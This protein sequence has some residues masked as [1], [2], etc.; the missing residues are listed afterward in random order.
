ML[1]GE[2]RFGSE[3]TDGATSRSGARSNA[4]GDAWFGS[5][6]ETQ[7]DCP[8]MHEPT[9]SRLAGKN[10]TT[11]ERSVLKLDVPLKGTHATPPLAWQRRY[12]HTDGWIEPWTR[13]RHLQRGLRFVASGHGPC[14]VGS[15]EAHAKSA[16]SCRSP[17]RGGSEL[18]V[19]RK[20]AVPCNSP[21]LSGF[22]PCFPSRRKWR[23]GDIAA[24]ATSPGATTFVRW[25]ISGRL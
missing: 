15:E 2:A 22:D 12:P 10:A 17:C 1:R 18:A 7:G 19:D 25:T 21:T 20:S 11:D 14:F 13:A 24:C 23:R 8:L 3:A 9:G 5:L 16:M 4:R 6:Q